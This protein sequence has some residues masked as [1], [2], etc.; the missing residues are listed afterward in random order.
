[1]NTGLIFLSLTACS[2]S[3]STTDTE[4]VE[5]A[6]WWEEDY[7]EASSDEEDKEDYDD[8]DKED[9][10]DEDKEDFGTSAGLTFE[11]SISTDDGLGTIVFSFV[12]EEDSSCS[13]EHEVVEAQTYTPCGSCDFA[14]EL[15][16]DSGDPVGDSNA[17][18][19]LDE[20]SEAVL[21][22]GHSTALIADYGG[23]SY[24]ELETYVDGTWGQEES[25]YSI[26]DGSTWYFATK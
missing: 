6:A 13:S 26:I 7:D 23:I 24:Y 21:I 22:Y 19:E 9:Y 14:W 11:A 16:L 10:D 1:M 3:K 18:A 25:G 15:T 2:N 12:G 8:E 5:E 4:E 17:C 20:F